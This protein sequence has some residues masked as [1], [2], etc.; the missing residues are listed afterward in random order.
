VKFAGCSL[1]VLASSWRLIAEA[2]LSS[3]PARW[4]WRCRGWLGLEPYVS[5][6]L[7]MLTVDMSFAVPVYVDVQI[8]RVTTDRAIFGVVLMRPG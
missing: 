7:L 6:R 2:N 4:L 3:I 5:A 8:H 1:N